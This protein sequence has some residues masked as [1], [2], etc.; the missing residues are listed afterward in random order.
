MSLSSLQR[1]LENQK[2]RA[3]AAREEAR[4]RLEA[5]EAKRR[6]FPWGTIAGVIGGGVVV[7]FALVYLLRA[8]FPG[9]AELALP[10]WVYTPHD[11]GPPPERHDAGPRIV[12]LPDAGPA[13]TGGHHGGTHGHGTGPGSS[14]GTGTP[15]HGHGLDLGSTDPTN[16]PLEGL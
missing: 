9:V 12:A 13:H 2:Q 6:A 14:S 1:E 7:F 8:S 16:D 5:E 3:V 15:A 4:E 10:D 11:A